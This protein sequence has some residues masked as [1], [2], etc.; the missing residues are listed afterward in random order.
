[1]AISIHKQRVKRKSSV[2]KIYYFSFES[3]HSIPFQFSVWSSSWSSRFSMNYFFH[4]ESFRCIL[5]S[6][7]IP[8][9]SQSCAVSNAERILFF[10]PLQLLPSFLLMSAEQCAN[11]DLQCY[12]NSEEKECGWAENTIKR[13]FRVHTSEY[14]RDMILFPISQSHSDL[15]ESAH[16]LSKNKK[17]SGMDRLVLGKFPVDHMK[18]STVW[19]IRPLFTDRVYLFDKILICAFKALMELE[20]RV[21][22]VFEGRTF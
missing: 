15:Y 1:M 5:L 21:Q 6:F 3:S 10:N 9:G 18:Y 2:Y 20:N 11:N 22:Y 8:V 12:L 17:S 4:F 14:R 7:F 16:G 13:A 19:G